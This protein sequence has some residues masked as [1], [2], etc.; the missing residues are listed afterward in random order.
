SITST[1]R[2][3]V[4]ELRSK[5]RKVG[6]CKI[7]YMRPF[8]HEDI[9]AL[10]AKVIGVL[11]KDISFG[12]EGTVF[13]NVNSALIRAQKNPKTVNFIAGLGGRSITKYDIHNMLDI[14]ECAKTG[15]KTEQVQFV[16]LRVK[17]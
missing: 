10:S 15:E 17:V 13:T 7:R 6:L 8:P 9:S 14:L 4:D 3:V 1:A 5:G 11:E 16:N 12:Y 2:I